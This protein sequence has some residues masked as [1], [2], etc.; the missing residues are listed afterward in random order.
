LSILFIRWQKPTDGCLMIDGPSSRG[1][2]KSL[3]SS[4][5]NLNQAKSA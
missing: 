3:A 5:L 4:Q 2:V 1:V